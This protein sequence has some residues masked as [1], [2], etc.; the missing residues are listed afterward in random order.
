MG[1][2][3]WRAA[4]DWPLPDTETKTLYLGAGGSLGE[5]APSGESAP[6]S[7]VYDPAD[8]TPTVGGSILSN[9]YP[10]GSC[11][12]SA[13]QARADVLTFET[14]PL[15]TDLDVVGN[16]VLTAWI[17]SSALDTDFLVRISD[18]F[19]D[20]RAIQL[21]SGALHARHREADAPPELLEPDK[22]YLFK[23]EVPATANR[24]MAG[25]RI[26]LDI[27]GADFPKFERHSNRADG[28]SDPL[29]A[30]QRIYHDESRPSQITLPTVVRQS[31]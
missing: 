20:G 31:Q 11:D 14:D 13:A 22:V 23:I 8:P 19:A 18:V 6:S 27:S 3:E 5:Q 10:A 30:H 17:S 25:H 29:S 4:S 21:Q 26:R 16:I 12:V 1:A 28:V 7:Y 2:N 15:A 9:V 24:F